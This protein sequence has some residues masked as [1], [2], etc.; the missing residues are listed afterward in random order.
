MPAIPEWRPLSAHEVVMLEVP[1]L[2]FL[3]AVVVG[4][5]FLREGDQEGPTIRQWYIS[6]VH[7][8]HAAPNQAANVGFVV[9]PA[10]GKLDELVDNLI[11]PRPLDGEVDRLGRHA[12]MEC[13][14]LDRFVGHGG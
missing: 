2:R 3:V 6:L 5:P 13:L 14:E 8:V 7:S 4:Q 1:Y 12:R 11:R 9:P 10:A